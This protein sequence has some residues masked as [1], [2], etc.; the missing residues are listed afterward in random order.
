MPSYKNKEDRCIILAN[1]AGVDLQSLQNNMAALDIFD[2]EGFEK[3]YKAYGRAVQRDLDALD[4]A[5]KKI[6]SKL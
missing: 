3:D 4:A 6:K 2:K 1:A 5:A